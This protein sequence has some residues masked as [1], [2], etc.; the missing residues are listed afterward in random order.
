MFALDN[1]G[2]SKVAAW[3][4][5]GQHE[6]C[7]QNRAMTWKVDS[8]YFST[9]KIIISRIFLPRMNDKIYLLL[10]MASPITETTE[11]GICSWGALSFCGTLTKP[12]WHNSLY[13]SKR[14]SLVFLGRLA[15]FGR[16]FNVTRRLYLFCVGSLWDTNISVEV[17][18]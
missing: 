7:F 2:K 11:L 14:P 18:I 16:C 13:R 5:P 10:S 8:F 12:H 17:Y 9:W 3:L 15:N 6:V 4:Q 1:T